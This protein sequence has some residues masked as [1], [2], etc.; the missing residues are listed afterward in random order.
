VVTYSGRFHDFL[1]HSSCNLF[2]YIVDGDDED[3]N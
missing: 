2:L 3:V 1:W